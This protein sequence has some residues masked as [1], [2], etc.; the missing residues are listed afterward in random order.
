[1]ATARSDLAFL[2]RRAGFGAS[3][4][5]LDA[6]V[7]GGYDAAVEALLGAGARPGAG[8][9]PEP[10]PTFAPLPRLA[11]ADG[12]T[13]STY[14]QMVREQGTELTGWWVRRM[15]ATADPFTEKLT[16]FWHGH[17]AT[18][19]TKVRVAAAM[20]AQNEIF[21][22]SGTGPFDA[23]TLAVA[24]DPAMLA[25]L[26]AGQNRKE[27]PNEN[28]ARELMELFT[29]GIGN[30]TETDVREAARAFT[31][32]RVDA[33]RTGFQLA[34]K[35]HDDGT[36]TVLG[37]TGNLGGEDVVALVTHQPASPRWV[38]SRLFSRFAAPVAPDAN[39]AADAMLAAYGST[40]DIGAAAAAML[41]SP[42]FLATRGKLVAQPVEY[43]V[44][45][46]R[47]LGLRVTPTA[48]GSAGAATG[49]A[50][51]GGAG[52]AAG[53]GAGSAA[54]GGAGVAAGSGAL[55]QRVVLAALA[56]LGQVPFQPP[57]VGGWPENA[58]WL[59]TASTQVRTRFA[60]AAAAAANLA[61][62]ADEPAA[63]RPDAVAHLLSLD[64]WTARTREAMAGAGGNPGRLVALAL[65]SPEYLTV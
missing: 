8:A 7:A 26:D 31:G 30:Y 34:A 43:V 39:P 16:F 41:R 20:L 46:L 5:Q 48:S 53:G 50:A 2:Y 38:C 63:G 54:G 4:A 37:R 56:G 15:V 14:A 57:S 28:F 9:D 6:A 1:M 32:W 61:V 36:K 17:F 25:W 13:R 24:R 49:A 51:G 42:A 35:Q 58:A 22:H 64:G 40:L 55:P 44:T 65:C 29:L 21:R 11:G 10:P 23:L 27:H 52:S 45:T 62:I 59:T 18:S 60:T 19:I 3:P 12:Q 33:S 47:A